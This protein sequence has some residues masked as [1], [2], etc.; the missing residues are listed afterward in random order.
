MKEIKIAQQRPLVMASEM[1]CLY[2]WRNN[3]VRF[4]GKTQLFTKKH[5]L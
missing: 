4:D 2:F 1:K 3:N 5:N